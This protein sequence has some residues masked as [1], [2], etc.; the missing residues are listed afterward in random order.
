MDQCRSAFLDMGNCGQ[1]F[2]NAGGGCEFIFE[3]AEAVGFSSD[4]HASVPAF[5]ALVPD[6]SAQSALGALARA[7]PIENVHCMGANQK[8]LPSVVKAVVTCVV[9]FHS[10][11][12]VGKKAMK[13]NLLLANVADDVSFLRRTVECSSP[14]PT[15]RL[16]ARQI[17]SVNKRLD[18]SAVAVLE[19]NGGNITANLESIFH[20]YESVS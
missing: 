10:G 11:R 6:D 9:N 20:V 17:G 12:K 13:R 2:L 16:H 15:E 18:Y 4:H 14:R 1:E 7:T 5:A 8:A 3:I 19:E